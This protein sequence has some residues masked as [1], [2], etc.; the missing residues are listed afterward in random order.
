[1]LSVCTLKTV[2]QTR[3]TSVTV[4]KPQA[5]QPTALPQGT[6]AVVNGQPLTLADLDPQLRQVVESLDKEIAE[7]RS[8]LLQAQINR[9][10]LE[11]EAKRR[12]MT[13]EQLMDVEVNKKI[14]AP[15][16]AEIKAVYDENKSQ[17][18]SADLPSVR[19]QI[20]TYLRN[21]QLQLLSGDLI[22][23]LRA[24][25]QFSIGTDVNA[26]NL[27][28]TA[29]LAT[30]GNRPVTAEL[31]NERFKPIG[32][33]MRR[34]V[35]DYEK[36]A[37]DVKIND[38]LLKAEAQKRNVTPPDIIRTEV[39]EKIHHPTDAEVAKFYEENKARINGD[40]ASVKSQ[41]A[42]YLEDQ[43]NQK[44]S[45]ALAERLRAGANFRIML[46]EPE[47]LAQKISADDDPARGDASAPVTVVEFTD[48]QCPSC[49]AMYPVIEETLKTY[50]N[51]VRFVLR[52]FPLD[53]HANARKA[54]EAADAA[55]AQGKFWEYIAIL[56]KNQSALDVPSLK[57]YASEIGLDRAKFDA[58]LD[59]GTYAAEV[60]RDRFDGEF[61]GV[62]ST[63]SIFINGIR[64]REMT[65]EAL[66][67][68][69]DR[70][71]SQA[72]QKAKSATR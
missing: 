47:E 38:A 1:M 23:R 18:G 60:S 33:D 13:P 35:Y 16:E 24:S 9:F 69:I 36:T 2:A 71:L 72:G 25:A 46:K 26:P 61:Y 49:G 67:A 53:Q 48:Y 34:R 17:L 31:L 8:Q 27:A 28:P 6:L 63:P 62:D 20:V 68:A 66:K 4:N 32:Y 42:Q 40:F 50:G 15:T 29:V 64:L 21:K 7:A 45:S 52:D 12:N 44:V 70:A 14:T 39:T 65:A 37:L 57:K 58:A 54:A 10:L 59:G 30:V 3:G 41:I 5:A 56:F 19:E 43:D 51:R 22:N 11:D 55:N